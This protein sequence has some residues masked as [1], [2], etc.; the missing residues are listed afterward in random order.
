MTATLDLILRPPPPLNYRQA[1]IVLGVTA[2]VMAIAAA[3]FWFLGAW[4]I[5]PFLIIDLSLLI[6]AFHAS[7]RGSKAFE[8]ICLSEREI[9]VERV[10]AGGNSQSY[11]LPRQWTRVEL[12]RPSPPV[13]R[14]WLTHRDRRLLIGHHLNLRER[15][16]VYRELR[17]ALG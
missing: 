9:R 1:L 15:A 6:W 7:A 10:G 14:L 3:R 5:L 2:L 12:G 16:E 4:M 11:T 8:R 17:R 13:S